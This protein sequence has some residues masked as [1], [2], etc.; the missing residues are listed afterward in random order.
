ME[1]FQF[2][3]SGGV[4]AKT[5]YIPLNNFFLNVQDLIDKVLCAVAQE[6]FPSKG[7][8]FCRRPNNRSS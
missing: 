4:V 2:V 5:H 7:K 3:N 1:F 8:S 6:F